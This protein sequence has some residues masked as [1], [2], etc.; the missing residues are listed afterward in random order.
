MQ[1]RHVVKLI[2][3]VDFVSSALRHA[4]NMVGGENKVNPKI[5][6]QTVMKRTY[7]VDS[8]DRALRYVV[9][10]DI[11]CQTSG[12]ALRYVMKW[13]YCVDSV[14]STLRYVVKW[15]YSED[16][17]EDEEVDRLPIIHITGTKGKGSTC[18]Y[19][20]NILRRHGYRTGLFTS[21]HL[22]EVLRRE[23]AS[24]DNLLVNQ[25]TAITSG[26]CIAS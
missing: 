13:I 14:D 15:I 25:S 16:C 18:A 19:T 22:V 10:V 24:T 20:E 9:E 5:K 8:A 3:K 2:F 12:S 4:S 6:C 26:K 11:M 1:L 7:C 23:F 17:K 21:P